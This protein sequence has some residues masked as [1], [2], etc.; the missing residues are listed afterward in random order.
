MAQL[1]EA[2]HYRSEGRGFD[3][4]WGHLD[5]SFT[6]PFRPHYDP[7]STQPPT[8]M[9]IPCGVKAAGA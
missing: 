6:L 8:L 9:S 3:S 7:G 4:S 2:L 1:D 5:F